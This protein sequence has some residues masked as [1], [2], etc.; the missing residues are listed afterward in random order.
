M[1]F[2]LSPERGRE[3]RDCF[4][5]P[6]NLR[7]PDSQTMKNLNK[8]FEGS[9]ASTKLKTGNFYRDIRG[10]VERDLRPFGAENF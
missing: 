4:T 5:E 2:K 9:K 1:F 8:I 3:R 7:G 6:G 10:P